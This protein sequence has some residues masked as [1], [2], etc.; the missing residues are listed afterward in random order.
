MCPYIRG[1]RCCTTLGLFKNLLN[2]SATVAVD[3]TAIINRIL[4]EF[5]EI[6]APKLNGSVRNLLRRGIPNNPVV[7]SSMN[8]MT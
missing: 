2:N 7:I 3:G 4:K 1:S 8:S 6:K 5:W